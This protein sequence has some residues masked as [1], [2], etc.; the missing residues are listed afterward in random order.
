MTDSVTVDGTGIGVAGR[1]EPLVDVHVESR[2]VWSFRPPPARAGVTR[3][4]AWPQPLLRYLRGVAAV[5]VVVDGVVA[6]DQEVRFGPEDERVSIVDDRGRGLIVDNSGRLAVTLGE[7]G[8]AAGHGPLLDALHDVVTSLTAAGVVA[9]PAYG[10]LL[11]TIRQGGFIAH[12][13]DADVAYI[14]AHEHPVDIIRESFRLQRMLQAE[15]HVITRHSGGGF[16][17][18]V[19]TADGST[20]GLDVFAGAM[21]GDHLMLMGE[22]FTPYRREWLLPTR[23]AELEGR[24]FPVPADAER[25]LARLYGEGWRVPDP[26]F[27][28]TKDPA[29][30]A[31]LD[32]WFRGTRVNRHHWDRRYS[33]ARHHGPKGRAHGLAR[34]VHREEPEA[35]VVDLGCGRGQDVAWLA[36]KG[37]RAIGLDY[38]DGGFAHLARRAQEK[39]WPAEYHAVNLLELRHAFGW[40]ARLA[41]LEGPVVVTARHLVDATSERGRRH[42]W[43]VCRMALAG[44]GRSYVEFLTGERG[45]LDPRT[46]LTP[47]DPDA[48]AAEAASYGA[49]VV[50]QESFG[51]RHT[52]QPPSSGPMD[53]DLPACRLVMEWTS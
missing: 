15:G 26:A 20:R 18:E 4:V 6:F 53:Q 35:T 40:G 50:A 38:A 8:T 24:P 1:G 41:R 3:L 9:F 52:G 12:D 11:G 48:V 16:K 22:L 34:L 37:H 46:L 14:S 5:R 32:G 29:V 10:T 43:R 39:G 47:L 33:T 30:E 45:P 17:V 21:V 2:R 28:F 13:T 44:G 19:A 31:R 23:T 36:R 27:S 51:A 7:Q 42:L 49:R 25:L